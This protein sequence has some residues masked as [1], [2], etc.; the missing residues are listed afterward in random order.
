MKKLRILLLIVLSISLFTVS[1]VHA[2]GSYSAALEYE[3]SPLVVADMLK[4]QVFYEQASDQLVDVGD[5]PK[6]LLLYQV[7]DAIRQGKLELTTEVEISEE[8]YALSQDYSLPNVPL[9]QDYTYSVE[10]LAE[11][12]IVGNANGAALALA[13][14]LAGSEVACLEQ[15]GNTLKSWGFKDYRLESVAGLKGTNELT[16]TALAV[17]TYHLLEVLPQVK[18][19]A[20]ESKITFAEGTSDAFD[21]NNPNLFISGVDQYAGGLGLLTNTAND[22]PQ[23]VALAED[24]G[25]LVAVVLLDFPTDE[26]LVTL[27][28][29]LFDTSFSSYLIETIGHKGD[30]VQHMRTV[31][32][33][34][35]K[36]TYTHL[37]YAEDFEAVLPVGDTAALLNYKLL[38]GVSYFNEANE[39]IAPLQ[40][41]TVIGQIQVEP[42]DKEM[43]TLPTALGNVVAVQLTEDLDEANAIQKIWR[44]FLKGW[45]HFWDAIR[46]FFIHLFN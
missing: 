1:T 4:G 24:S 15:M 37:A 8:A 27:T 34:G 14:A 13:E 42:R 7:G 5:L 32:V 29:Q 25:L 41:K 43:K 10:A 40:E 21:L 16:A 30:Q 36:A 9:R 11:A 6:L 2:I 39:L 23:H 19:W 18:E 3:E 35:G 17:S 12:V 22:K 38:P 26:R 45:N 20:G 28:N 46:Q 33:A 31:P 44:S